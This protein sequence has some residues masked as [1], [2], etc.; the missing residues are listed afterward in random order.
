MVGRKSFR[1]H[2]FS[3]LLTGQE[4]PDGI[5][6]LHKCDVPFCVRPD[7]LFTGT[8]KDNTR[9]AISKGRHPID[10]IVGS[11]GERHGASKLNSEK[12]KAMRNEHANGDGFYVL[13]KRYGVS[14]FAA[15]KAILGRTW[16][17]V[18]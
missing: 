9:D 14:K 6:V 7:H 15:K 5:C 10:N 16:A 12:V 13:G 3:F 8:K 17:H 1:A 4:I 18:T 11:F 2:R